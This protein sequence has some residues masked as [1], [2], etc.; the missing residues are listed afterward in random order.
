M[1]DKEKEDPYAKLDYMFGTRPYEV[2]AAEL[3]A[4]FKP[5]QKDE[6]DKNEDSTSSD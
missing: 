4:T 3:K 2:L 5:D 1:A 6:E